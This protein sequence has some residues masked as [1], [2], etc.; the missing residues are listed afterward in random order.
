MDQI[1]FN[2][3][4]TAAPSG[5]PWN[6]FGSIQENVDTSTILLSA[7]STYFTPP[8]GPFLNVTR[9]SYTSNNYST[10]TELSLPGMAADSESF[11]TFTRDSSTGGI[12]SFY[13]A[14]TT[15]YFL[16]NTFGPAG[17]GALV[18]LGPSYTTNLTTSSAVSSF[19]FPDPMPAYTPPAGTVIA[20]WSSSV[21][22]GLGNLGVSAP[23][24]PDET[25]LTT[26]TLQVSS[27]QST[28]SSGLR[29]YA[30]LRGHVVKIDNTS[31]AVSWIRSGYTAGYMIAN[32]TGTQGGMGRVSLPLDLTFD[33][34]PAPS[35]YTNSVGSTFPGVQ[36]KLGDIVFFDPGSVKN[37]ADIV[38]TNNGTGATRNG[39]GTF[40]GYLYVNPPSNPT[41]GM[42]NTLPLVLSVSVSAGAITGINNIVCC[43]SGFPDGTALYTMSWD[44]NDNFFYTVTN[45][46]VTPGIT[47][48]YTQTTLP[49]FTI[50]FYNNRAA[51]RFVTMND[52]GDGYYWTG[53]AWNGVTTKETPWGA[54]TRTYTGYGTYPTLAWTSASTS[55]TGTFNVTMPPGGGLRLQPY[56]LTISSSGSWNLQQD[57]D[58]IGTVTTPNPSKNLLVFTRSGRIANTG[59]V[60][61]QIYPYWGTPFFPVNGTPSA[62]TYYLGQF[63]VSNDDLQTFQYVKLPGLTYQPNVPSALTQGGTGPAA[64]RLFYTSV[65][66]SDPLIYFLNLIGTGVDDNMYVFAAH[67]Y[68]EYDPASTASS[69]YRYKLKMY[70]FQPGPDLNDINTGAVWTLMWTSPESTSSRAP[71]MEMVQNFGGN[72]SLVVTPNFNTNYLT[73]TSPTEGSVTFSLR[74]PQMGAVAFN[75]TYYFTFSSETSLTEIPTPTGLSWT[76]AGTPISMAYD[77]VNDRYIGAVGNT[78]ASGGVAPGMPPGPGFILLGAGESRWATS[79]TITYLQNAQT[80]IIWPT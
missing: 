74:N 54:T 39:G 8:S 58:G 32:P 9:G 6:R 79:P 33:S 64:G 13:E 80:G 78:A 44:T 7:T 36:A 57:T 62:Y 77:V 53:T 75:N 23:S 30:Q 14:A 10:F 76:P 29:N 11:R 19:S 27:G 31:K 63:V 40:T 20:S 18:S 61:N 4:R 35:N 38:R 2:R 17:S 73:N 5:T 24:T 47:A 52:F 70:H 51:I 59:V 16:L 45:G 46:S 26:T 66:E 3:A 41:T 65:P 1:W 37:T 43:G 72:T 56:D 71:W 22:A 67:C 60:N 42:R 28:P 12:L 50:T 48:T 55:E 25:F 21:L 49:Q 34:I 15:P 69:V 68:G